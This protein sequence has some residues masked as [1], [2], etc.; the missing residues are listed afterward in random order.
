LHGLKALCRSARRLQAAEKKAK[1]GVD[2]VWHA[3]CECTFVKP[4]KFAM[5][6]LCLCDVNE[7]DLQVFAE[8]AAAGRSLAA[9]PEGGARAE[10]CRVGFELPEPMHGVSAVG[11][12]T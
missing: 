1:T 5:T 9:S 3:F 4:R 10:P 11:A 2:R 7:H 8:I 6:T 12:L